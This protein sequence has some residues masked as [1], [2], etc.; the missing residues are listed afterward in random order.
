M[1]PLVHVDLAGVHTEGVFPD[2]G[3]RP[4]VDIVFI[5]D[6]EPHPGIILLLDRS[7]SMSVTTDGIPAAQFVQEAG[8]F[9]YHSSE[10]TDLVGTSL[11]NESVEELFPYAIYDPANDL[12]FVSFRSADGMTDIAKALAG[13]I[14]A[15]LETHGE[16]GVA[17]AEIYLLSDG[18]QTTGDSLW[19]Q[20]ARANTRGIRINTFSFGSADAGVMDAIAAGTSGDAI[21]VSER[22]D[23]A[24]LK[25]IMARK[26]ATGRGRTPVFS[27]KGELT[28]LYTFGKSQAAGGTFDIPP[29]SRNL[30][31]YA[32]LRAKDASELLSLALV[33]PNGNTVG[34]STPDNII[35]K[36]RFNAVTVDTPMPGSWSWWGSSNVGGLPDDPVELV[37][38]ADNR[39]LRGR[40]WFGDFRAD[41]SLVAY[42]KLFF[43]Y[44]LSG[45]DVTLGLYRQGR[46]IAELPMIDDG[47]EGIDLQPGDGIYSA[48]VDVAELLPGR[49]PGM[50]RPSYVP[51]PQTLR[52]EVRFQV[53]E[54]SGPAPNAIYEAGITPEMV[55]AEPAAPTRHDGWKLL[56]TLLIALLFLWWL[57]RYQ[58]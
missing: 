42:A 2:P 55:G 45:L 1:L 41:G 12:P 7:G 29:K 58:H 51:P 3:P 5:G 32:F 17:G 33:D 18:R 43:R 13:A 44:P 24:E 40:L 9:L 14:D 15:L 57:R 47:A 30:G 52:V 27:F 16:G 37:A 25:L 48:V 26:L 11:Y 56:L 19:D 6:D 8:M 23:A 36:G 28:P 35:Q 22:Q 39:E 31:F 53:T 34:S 46:L 50:A 38:Y 10:P 49:K 21:P 54:A 4:D 20:V